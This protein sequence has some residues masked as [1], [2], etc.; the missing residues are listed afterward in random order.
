MDYS[1]LKKNFAAVN[2]WTTS[3]VSWLLQT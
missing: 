2:L 3:N 1:E